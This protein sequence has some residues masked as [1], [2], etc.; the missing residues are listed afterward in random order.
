MRKSGN[1]YSNRLFRLYG[2]S[3]TSTDA[4]CAT[5]AI[6]ATDGATAGAAGAA[7]ATGATGLS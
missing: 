2:D 6:G 5:V 7:G 3:I 4:V 1:F